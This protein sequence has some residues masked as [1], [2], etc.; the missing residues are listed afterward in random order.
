[1][2]R[3]IV[4]L[5]IRNV[6]GKAVFILREVLI[7]KRIEKGMSRLEVAKMLGISEVFVRK[8]E[9]ADRNPSIETMLK[10]ELLYDISMRI[11]FPDV[12]QIPVDTKRIVQE[13][14]KT[15]WNKTTREE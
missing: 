4:S 11:L 6:S 3:V 10:F 13:L 12:F 7:E 8:I 15:R 5:L 1:M 14:E 2:Y 9:S